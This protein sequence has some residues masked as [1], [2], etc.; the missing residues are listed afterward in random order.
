M[1]HALRITHHVSRITY[2]ASR[3]T[4]CVFRILVLLSVMALLLGR[5]VPAF[6]QDDITFT[7]SVD[8]TSITTDELLTLELRLAGAFNRSSQPQLPPLDGFAVMGSSQSSQFSIINGAMSSQ[9]V[10]TYRLQP[11]RT[12]TL[13]IPAVSIQMGNQTYQTDPITV[14]VTQGAAPQAG[15]PTVEAPPDATAPSQLAGQDLYVE[16]DV[17][18]IR[19]VVGQQIIY[20]FR[21]YQA[22]NLMRQPSLDWPD[23]TGFL[24]YDLSPN[25]QYYHQAAGRRYLVTE[26]RRALFPTAQGEVT[27][28]PATLTIPGD[29][30][31]R[32]IQMQTDPVTVDVRPLPDGDDTPPDF[33]G[34][35]GQYEIEAWVEPPEGRVNEPVTLFV[36]V[37]GVGNVSALSD[38]TEGLEEALAGWRVYD[39]QV[40]TDVGQGG[41]F[42]RG[43]K[44]FERPL[45]PRTE[46]ELII[47]AFGLA[48][49]DPEVGEYRRVQSEPLV[50]QIAPG[51]AQPAG[52]VVVGT[53]KQD[54]VVLASDIRHIKPA[55]PA[56]AIS[57]TSLLGQPLYWVGW[58]VGLLAVVGV[59]WWDRRR[60]QL[61]RDVAYARAQRARRQARKRL[62]EA[63]RLVTTDED[64]AY[65]AVARALT[66]YLGDKWNLP[67]AGLTRDGISR[68]LTAG[69]VSDD[70][71]DRLRVCLDWA[72]SGRFAPVGAG[73]DADDL[74]KEAEEVIAELE[75]SIRG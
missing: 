65:A 53:G 13:T 58:S 36:R 38:P 14:E 55:P 32:A 21:L 66:A 64:A 29:F 35:V 20:R 43:E 24:G 48:F 52:P 30:F 56:L 7:A 33:T 40:T 10:F 69:S 63:R 4:Y 67:A 42:I 75:E 6:A 16:A 68:T 37:S 34:A 28:G 71:V 61:A 51:E 39:P 18:K 47:P 57:H 11:I 62:S 44:L 41:D 19:P 8:R 25:N 49:F 12:G 72:D 59:W 26:V 22:V 60:H 23:F 46:G 70:L 17:S 45:V 1:R 73:R 2:H 54:V 9:V 5:A 31:N 50:V 74:I 3:I 27:I 15:Q